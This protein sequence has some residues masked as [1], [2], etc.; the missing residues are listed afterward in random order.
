MSITR[1]RHEPSC[2]QSIKVM[3]SSLLSS[4][5]K[6]FPLTLTIKWHHIHSGR[7]NSANHDPIAIALR[8]MGYEA[9]MVGTDA[10]A[11]RVGE[12]RYKWRLDSTAKVW[13]NRF[14]C[15]LNVQPTTIQLESF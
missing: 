13:V 1:P 10:V 14:D 12:Q 15:G 6:T 2:K 4:M 5:F 8:D 11:A 9:I 7:I 3:K